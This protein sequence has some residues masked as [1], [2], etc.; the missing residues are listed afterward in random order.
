MG[1]SSSPSGKGGRCEY[2]FGNEE[3]GHLWDRVPDRPVTLYPVVGA[4][5]V[6]QS[7]PSQPR[8]LTVTSKVMIPWSRSRQ[9]CMSFILTHL[10][11]CVNALIGF[12]CFFMPESTICNRTCLL[13][14]NFFDQLKSSLARTSD[15]KSGESNCFLSRAVKTPALAQFAFA[16]EWVRVP[17]DLALQTTKSLRRSTAPYPIGRSSTP[18]PCGLPRRL[19]QMSTWAVLPQG[20]SIFV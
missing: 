3:C 7:S 11:V 15:L 14:L 5:P 9:L 10:P 13:L 19:T 6:S 16:G 20:R 12:V 1:R 8:A 2:D 18:L 4:S 17:T